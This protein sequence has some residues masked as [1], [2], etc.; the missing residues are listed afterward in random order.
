MQKVLLSPFATKRTFA[1]SPHA[2]HPRGGRQQ[3]HSFGLK[4]LAMSLMFAACAAHADILIG[5]TAD[6]SGPVAAGV[7]EA[8]AGAKL[9]IN[10][11][12]ANGGVNGEPIVIVAMDDKFEPAI[13]AANARELTRNSYVRSVLHAGIEVS[14]ISKPSA[15]ARRF[16]AATLRWCCCSS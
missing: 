16:S 1:Y 12:N 4:S 14:L 7:K 13:A 8:A 15:A 2:G 6:F 5:Q 11:V 10:H 9:Y 3:M